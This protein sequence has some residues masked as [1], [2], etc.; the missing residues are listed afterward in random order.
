MYIYI[1][2]VAVKIFFF[3]FTKL[4]GT[5]EYTDCISAEG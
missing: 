2:C 3:F 1:F 5:E 4:A